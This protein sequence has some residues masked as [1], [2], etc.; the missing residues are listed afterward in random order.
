MSRSAHRACLAV[1]EPGPSQHARQVRAAAQDLVVHAD[2]AAPAAQAAL[3]RIVQAQQRCARRP[4]LQ[5]GGRHRMQE[6]IIIIIM[7]TAELVHA[8]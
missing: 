7:Q 8:G 6:T 1:H 2:A 4:K 3:H 5:D